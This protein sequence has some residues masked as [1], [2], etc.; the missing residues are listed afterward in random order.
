MF[1]VEE[2]SKETTKRVEKQEGKH[3]ILVNDGDDDGEGH[4]KRT[5]SVFFSAFPSSFGVDVGVG[6]SDA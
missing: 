5:P 6:G 2:Q 3:F 4:M 1:L